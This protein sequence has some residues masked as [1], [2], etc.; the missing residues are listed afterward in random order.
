[1]SKRAVFFGILLIAG[2][3]TNLSRAEDAIVR[4]DP[5]NNP[6]YPVQ[7]EILF[8]MNYSC[9]TSRGCSFNCPGVGSASNVTT[10]E[11]YVGTVPLGKNQNSPALFYVFSTAQLPRG[12]GFSINN[13]ALSSLAC[14]VNGMK[15][16]YSGP[17]K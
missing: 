4:P 8:Q 9:P 1:M 6:P 3:V 15:Q 12:N 5:G 10:F 7:A 2:S 11:L 13:G 16:D 17:A 14:Q